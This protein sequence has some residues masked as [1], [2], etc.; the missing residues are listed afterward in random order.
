MTILAHQVLNLF[1]YSTLWVIFSE[2]LKHSYISH[3]ARHSNYKL[4]TS[5]R[6]KTKINNGRE[7]RSK[8]INHSNLNVWLTPFSSDVFGNYV[9]QKFFEFGTIEQKSALVG[10]IKG[11][12]LALAL[13][14]YG[15]R[16]IQKALECIPREQQHELVMTIIFGFFQILYVICQK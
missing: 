3:K 9:I 14:M 11:H 6:N 2:V 7:L 12:M 15:C 1:G 16:V 8:E 5:F 4:Y 10:Y 13:Q